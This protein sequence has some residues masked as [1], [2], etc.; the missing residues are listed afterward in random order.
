MIHDLENYTY[1]ERLNALNLPSLKYRRLH[2]DMILIY[3][4]PHNHFNVDTSDLITTATLSTTRGHDHKL[5]KPRANSRV[6][7]IFFIVRAINDWNG[8]PNHV[9][10]APTISDFK[11]SLGSSRSTMFSA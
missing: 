9:V 5:F 8:L 1:N 3:Q 11:N 6:R 2:G 7:S 4:L 10:N